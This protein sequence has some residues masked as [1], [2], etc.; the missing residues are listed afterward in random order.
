[1]NR[2]ISA[3]IKKTLEGRY[4][5][6]NV[7]VK[8]QKLFEKRLKSEGGGKR[9]YSNLISVTVYKTQDE[10]EVIEKEL[11]QLFQD[12]HPSYKYDGPYVGTTTEKYKKIPE[13]NGWKNSRIRG[14]R[15]H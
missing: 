8:I 9:H 12:K 13:D 6:G 5:E 11:V 1:M 3:E 14:S 7:K 4:G 10:D 15:W 2:E